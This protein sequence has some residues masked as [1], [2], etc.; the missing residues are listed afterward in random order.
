MNL[1]KIGIICA[2]SLLI[3]IIISFFLLINIK[4]SGL[5]EECEEKVIKLNISFDDQEEELNKIKLK[6]EDAEK[7]YLEQQ[8][9]KNKKIIQDYTNYS[10]LCCVKK[11]QC[12]DELRDVKL[13]LSKY[14]D[15]YNCLKY[16]ET[17]VC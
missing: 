11:E 14:T 5:I 2:I 1:I 16:N 9:E 17:E 8:K 7:K 4:N 12:R 10:N 6:L 3:L 13:N 15:K